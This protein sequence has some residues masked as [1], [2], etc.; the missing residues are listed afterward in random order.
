MG[1]HADVKEQYRS[2]V[3][4]V[5]QGLSEAILRE[6]IPPGYHEGIKGYFD[7]IEE[8]PPAGK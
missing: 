2:A 4:D 6:E 1:E 3:R 7:S 8:T 5:K